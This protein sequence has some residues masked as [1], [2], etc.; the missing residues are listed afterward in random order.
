MGSIKITTNNSEGINQV[1]ASSKQKKLT[2]FNT[3]MI[4]VWAMYYLQNGESSGIDPE[5]ERMCTKFT[6]NF[7]GSIVFQVQPCDSVAEI[8]TNVF[9]HPEFGS[10]LTDCY[11]VKVYTYQFPG[12]G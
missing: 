8:S 3:Y 11:T 2:Y 6:A 1:T 10:T 4:P 9:P 12:E 5:E 7:D